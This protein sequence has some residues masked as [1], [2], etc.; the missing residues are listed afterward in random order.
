[1]LEWGD[2]RGKSQ[3]LGTKAAPSDLRK[4]RTSLDCRYQT[5]APKG[6]AKRGAWC[7]GSS[8]LSLQ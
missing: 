3:A 5:N 1:M 7:K 2:P 4:G 6:K 8:K